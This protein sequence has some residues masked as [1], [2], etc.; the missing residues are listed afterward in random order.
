MIRQFRILAVRRIPQLAGVIPALLQFGLKGRFI[1]W[2][3]VPIYGLGFFFFLTSGECQRQ[4][5]KSHKQSHFVYTRCFLFRSSLTALYFLLQLTNCPDF[6][7]T[8]IDLPRGY[9][10]PGKDRK[11]KLQEHEKN[12]ACAGGQKY[13]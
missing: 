9:D 11:E 10:E 13:R 8:L 5:G 3:H 1:P 6:L 12:Q 7:D 4:Y 2:G